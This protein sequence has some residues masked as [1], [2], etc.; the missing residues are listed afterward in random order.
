VL[1]PVNRVRLQPREAAG[2]L[3][4][5]QSLR[6]LADDYLQ[7]QPGQVRS[8]TE[9]LS[10]AEGEMGIGISGKVKLEWFLDNL[11]VAIGGKL[12]QAHRLDFANPLSTHL[13]VLGGGARELNYGRRPEVIAQNGWIRGGLT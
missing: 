11:F 8:N 10:D 1:D 13:R 3:H 5:F 12:D 9:M 2:H 6:E 4:R 7:F